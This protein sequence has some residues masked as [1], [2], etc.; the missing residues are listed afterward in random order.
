MSEDY[1]AKLRETVKEWQWEA[2]KKRREARE[3]ELC[4]AVIL[5]KSIQL[6]LLAD[7]LERSNNVQAE[8][9]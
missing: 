6:D 2:E 3:L 7:K 5:D 1:I 8:A 9:A 4:A